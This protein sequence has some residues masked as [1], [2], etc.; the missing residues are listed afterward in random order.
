[1]AEKKA[2]DG[3]AE[4]P[5]PR[6]E[7]T[8]VLN[9][10]EILRMAQVESGG[11]AE[12]GNTAQLPRAEL[13]RA[14]TRAG[15][16]PDSGRDDTRQRARVREERPRVIR[17]GEAHAGEN[18]QGQPRRDAGSPARAGKREAPRQR[19]AEREPRQKT[20]SQSARQAHPQRQRRQVT[21]GQRPQPQRSQQP[22]AQRRQVSGQRPA[23]SPRPQASRGQ[24]SRPQPQRRQATHQRAAAAGAARPSQP[25]QEPR[26]RVQPQ[27]VPDVRN[28][29]S[30]QHRAA[31]RVQGQ[32]Q[33]RDQHRTVTGS[34]QARSQQAVRHTAG[35]RPQVVAQVRRGSAQ[36]STGAS[37][38]REQASPRQ[39]Q[40][41][42]Q[43]T[44]APRQ[45]PART[46]RRS[47]AVRV[48]PRQPQRTGHAGEG[49]RRP[50]HAPDGRRDLQPH[51]EPRRRTPV[52]AIAAA[53]VIV[54]VVVFAAVRCNN[55]RIAEQQ[56]AEQQ[57]QAQQAQEQAKATQI[58][59]LEAGTYY[60]EPIDTE[61][62][63]LAFDVSGVG[64]DAYTTVMV[65]ELT[66]TSAQQIKLDIS[67][68]GSTC[69]LTNG[70]LYL[71]AGDVTAGSGRS[72]FANKSDG[73]DTQRWKL[74][75][76][77]DGS[78]SIISAASDDLA[79]AVESAYDGAPV[80]VE[81]T[82]S[83]SDAQHFRILAQSRV[84]TSASTNANTQSSNGNASNG[85]ANASASAN[86]NGRS[87]SSNSSTGE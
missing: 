35:S 22:A 85:N 16:I 49:Q 42:Q 68:D 51:D 81:D 41:R 25:R 76:N 32:P 50:P 55:A 54:L 69:T 15:H 83:T 8:V 24:A 33:Q 58:A 2:Q 12:A 13:D 59:G 5:T 65:S 70:D 57:Q 19:P 74:S 20:P 71:D 6:V 64:D 82:D 26:R 84:G 11:R 60:I 67:D 10:D 21:Q 34:R 37:V 23:Q 4:E 46:Q 53:V 43:E 79:I 18:R 75:K 40:P 14:R 7:K 63:V 1:M 48:R 31:Q 29:P 44:R 28:A 17:E 72:L 80:T 61:S 47:Q 62:G 30:G 3:Q 86:A 9:R 87:N 78:Y 66:Q 52:I 38:A 39:G 27:R 45:Q 36:R 77:S 56:A 73:G